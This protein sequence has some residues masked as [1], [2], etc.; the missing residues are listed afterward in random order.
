MTAEGDAVLALAYTQVGQ[1]NGDP[2][3]AWY[4]ADL[5]SYCACFVSWC[6]WHAGYPVCPIDSSLGFVLVSNGTVHSYENGEANPTLDLQPGDVILFSWYYWDW[7]G[8][9]PVITEDPWVGWIAGDHTGFFSHWID[10]SAGRFATV[11]GNTNGGVVA[12]REDR[13]TSQVCGW[14]RTPATEGA[15]PPDPIIPV[16]PPIT[17]YEEC[18]DMIIGQDSFTGR[19]WLISGNTKLEFPQGGSDPSSPGKGNIYVDEWIRQV[20]QSYPGAPELRL[21]ALNPDIVGRIPEINTLVEPPM[22][23][24]D[25]TMTDAD[26]PK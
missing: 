8:G 1:P 19:I 24:M 16:P 9:M 6:G 21:C 18:L 3:W 25:V 11:E 12:Y 13:Y 14:W 23:A 17:G 4:G 10:Q 2:Y 7:Q 5:G 26:I 22:T 15:W 20:A